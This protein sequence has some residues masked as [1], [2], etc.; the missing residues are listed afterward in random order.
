MP[1][2]FCSGSYTLQSPLFDCEVLMDMYCEQPESP[3]AKSQI[4]MLH[5]P[6]LAIR[7]QLPEASVPNLFTVNGRSFAAATNFYEL[8]TAFTNPNLGALNGAPLSSTQIF[9]NQTH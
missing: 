1:F 6:G 4:T 5:R 7:Y 2:Q 3:N 8:K 9:S